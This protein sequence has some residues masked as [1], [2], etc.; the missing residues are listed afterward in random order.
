MDARAE[1][2]RLGLS[3]SF[4]FDDKPN[5]AK[6]YLTLGREDLTFALVRIG[7]SDFCVWLRRGK[8]ELK[9]PVRYILL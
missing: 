3:V 6:G 7:Y 8:E 2:R 4:A 1:V 5:K 9:P